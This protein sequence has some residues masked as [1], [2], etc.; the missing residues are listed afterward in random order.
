MDTAQTSDAAFSLLHSA[1]WSVGDSAYTDP[2]IGR[3]TWLVYCHRGEQQVIA[4]ADTQAMAWAG[5]SDGRLRL[6]PFRRRDVT[7]SGPC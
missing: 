6:H 7:C 3:L 4:K 2:A 1:D 5:A